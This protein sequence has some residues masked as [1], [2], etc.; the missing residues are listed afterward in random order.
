V[1]N[2]LLSSL[3]SVENIF[4]EEKTLMFTIVIQQVRRQSHLRLRD[5]LINFQKSS[6]LA[7]ASEGVINLLERFLLLAGGANANAGEGTVGAQQVLYIL[8]AL[9]ECLPLLSLKYKNNI[10]KHFKTLLVL[11][12][13]LVTRRIT[14]SLSFLCLYPTSEVSPEALL[15]VLCT[16]SALSTSSNEMSGDGMTF[17]ARLLEAGMKKVFSLDRQM[18]VI[19]LPSVF[20]DLKGIANFNCVCLYSYLFLFGN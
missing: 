5:V 9:K 1:N 7:S 18:C 2:I 14:D 16:L 13:P 11:R 6:L 8:D 20:N 4:F 12:Q 3:W 15:E 19:K 17:T 10:L